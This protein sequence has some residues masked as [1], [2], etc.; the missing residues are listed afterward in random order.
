MI[1]ANRDLPLSY[2]FKNSLL[3]H[4]GYPVFIFSESGHFLKETFL[5]DDPFEATSR[6]TDP[7]LPDFARSQRRSLRQ[8]RA[9]ARSLIDEDTDEEVGE[10][11][12]EGSSHE[13]DRESRSP[14]EEERMPRS[15]FREDKVF[16]SPLKEEEKRSLQ[17]EQ[18]VR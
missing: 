1:L 2:S 6:K 10:N 3:K 11:E 8:A 7:V 15:S 12:G 5:G 18:R 14:V 9:A 4:K 17:E 13:E 16:G